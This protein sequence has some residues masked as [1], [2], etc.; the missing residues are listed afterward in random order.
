MGEAETGRIIV[1]GQLGT[2]AA[3]L[4]SKEKRWVSWCAPAIP[5]MMRSIKSGFFFFLVSQIRERE[6][7]REHISKLTRV[8]RTKVRAQ[9]V[10]FLPSKHC[11]EFKSQNH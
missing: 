10:E 7:E 1:P 2:K 5:A 9:E 3:E 11:L 6:R 4:I 8:R